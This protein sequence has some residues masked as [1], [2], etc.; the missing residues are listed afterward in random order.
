MGTELK[1]FKDTHSEGKDIR[2]TSFWG[3]IIRGRCLQLSSDTGYVCISSKEAK[4][5]LQL[6]YDLIK[7]NIIRGG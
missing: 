3:G 7:D 6:L 2:V 5:L 1:I 4:D